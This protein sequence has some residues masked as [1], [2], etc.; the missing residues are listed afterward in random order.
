MKLNNLELH[1]FFQEKEILHL[2][3]A[4]TVA[5]SVSFIL[6]GGLLSRGD[7][8]HSTL[9]QTIQE[10]DEEDK[11]FD[12]WHDVFLDT[13]DLHGYFPR[14]N[15]YGPVLFK[16]DINFLLQDDV[17]V[18][19]TKNNPMYWT[20]ALS[21]EERY[22]QSV[23]ELRSSW[24]QY[25]RQKKM[26]TIR[27]PGRPVLFSALEEIVIDDPRIQIHG[28]TH[29]FN[30]MKTALFS[31]TEGFQGLRDKFII[32]ECGYCYCRDNYLHQVSTEQS[33]RLFLPKEHIHF[34]D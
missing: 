16:F 1:Q 23:D 12:V 13:A 15:L 32:R 34:P 7:I 8:E 5:T 2:H 25:E 28:D 10:S 24:D 4:N 20:A 3:H 11:E 21:N 27:K 9:T 17:D 18:W 29:M 6:S 33:A 26:I 31:S 14:Q 19:I 22:F 30:E